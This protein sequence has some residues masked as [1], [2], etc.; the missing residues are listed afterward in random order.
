MLWCTN[1]IFKRENK[2]RRVQLLS[3]SFQNEGVCSPK[4]EILNSWSEV[5]GTLPSYSNY[6][7]QINPNLHVCVVFLGNNIYA[8]RIGAMGG[9]PQNSLHLQFRNLCGSF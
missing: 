5:K 6:Y 2:L 8:F 1:F 9:I 4:F 7:L 3:L